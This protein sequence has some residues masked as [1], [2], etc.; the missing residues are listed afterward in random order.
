MKKIISLLFLF[1][2]LTSCFATIGGDANLSPAKV[3]EM[4]EREEKIIKE[5]L[6]GRKLEPIEGIWIQ[7][8]SGGRKQSEAFYKRGDIYLRI[9][10]RNGSVGKLYKISE[11]E[12]NGTCHMIFPMEEVEGDLEII[13][14]DDDSLAASCTRKDYIT[15]WE[16]IDTQIDNVTRC[17]W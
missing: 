13:S 17:W 9:V 16:K 1:L 12:F 14:T 7:E 5:Q 15:K 11:N 3:L 10:L 6:S 2:F 4:Q 8:N